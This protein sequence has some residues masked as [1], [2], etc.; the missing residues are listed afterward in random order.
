LADA[1]AEQVDPRSRMMGLVLAGN[2]SQ[3]IATA[4]ELEL[5]RA[6]SGGALAADELAECCGA[7]ERQLARLMRVLTAFGVFARADDERYELTPIGS[8]LLADQEDGHSLAGMALF[9]GSA[10][11][12]EARGALTESVRTGAS[13]FRCAHGTDLA[14]AMQRDPELARLWELWAG[15]SAGIDAQAGPVLESYDFSGARHLVDVGG[16]YGGLL[17]EILLAV[18][19]ATGTVFD[20]PDAE[21]G[22]RAHL[23]ALGLEARANVVAGSFFDSVPEGGD[24][25][26]ISNVL[27]DWDDE[28]AVEL[29]RN[30]RTAMAPDSRLLVIEPIFPEPVLQAAGTSLLDLW[31]MFHSGGMRTVDE[32]GELL[33][34]ADLEVRA[35]IQT[36]SSAATLVE[37]ARP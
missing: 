6:L 31:M 26:I 14:D 33:R 15:Y 11:L 8:T 5:P 4:V 18:P 21:A 1:G 16:R 10:R 7:N 9:A 20:L 30:C 25:Y 13:A 22:A 2:V 24:L 3:A 35:V 28:R 27:A 12:L 17:A 32:V 36:A 23:R 34:T 37:A 29:L 19:D